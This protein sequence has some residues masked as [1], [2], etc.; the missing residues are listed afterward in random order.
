MAIWLLDFFRRLVFETSTKSKTFAISD[1][2]FNPSSGKKKK[3][4]WGY[5]VSAAC[6]KP[7]LPLPSLLHEEGHR[8]YFHNFSHANPCAI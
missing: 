8:F 7:E 3:N 6:K 1:F 5:I 4:L 2:Y